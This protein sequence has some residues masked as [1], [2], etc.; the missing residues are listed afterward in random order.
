MFTGLVEELGKVRSLSRGAHSIRLTIAAE[1]VLH[2]VKMGDSIAV[3]GACLTVVDFTTSSFTVDV[4]PETFDRTTLSLRKSGDTV[5]LERTLRVGDRL[6]GHIVSGHVDSV[7]DLVSVTP[8]DNA[9]IL[10]VQVPRNLAPFMIPQGSVAVDG[11]SLTI[12]DCGEDWFEVS[13]I[14]HTWGVTILS[15][16][17][18]GDKVNVETDVLGKYIYRMAQMKSVGD[19]GKKPIGVDFLAQHGFLD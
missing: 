8:R 14:P 16:K 3:D 1:K 10:R 13:L 4:M 9:N 17:R 5:N 15:G 6:G 19:T 18:A 11:V 2:D 7:A 12:V